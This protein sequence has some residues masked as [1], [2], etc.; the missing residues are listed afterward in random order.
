MT[1]EG[2]T[3]LEG[4]DETPDIS[5]FQIK[6]YNVLMLGESRSGKSRFI[7][8]LNDINFLGLYTNKS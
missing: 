7:S 3:Q 2:L 8:I 1:D 4:K 6:T 5:V